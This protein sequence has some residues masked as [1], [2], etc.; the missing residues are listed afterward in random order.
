MDLL[1]FEVKG[2]RSRL[3]PGRIWLKSGNIHTD[4]SPTMHMPPPFNPLKLSGIRWLHLLKWPM[5]SRYNL[6]FKF[7]TFGHS[8]VQGW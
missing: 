8:G 7:M 1:D 2:Q 6:H 4:G 3:W 5:P